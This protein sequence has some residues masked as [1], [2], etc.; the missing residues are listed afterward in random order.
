MNSTTHCQPELHVG[1]EL[2]PDHK[3]RMNLATAQEL[4]KLKQL[5]R[6]D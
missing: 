6:L 4:N 1:S 5:V 2:V 3:A